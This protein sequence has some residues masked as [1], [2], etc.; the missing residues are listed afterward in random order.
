MLH[1]RA[2][3]GSSRG[4]REAAKVCMV[5]KPLLMLPP[6]QLGK[7]LHYLLYNLPQKYPITKLC[8]SSKQVN[9]FVRTILWRRVAERA[10]RG[11]YFGDIPAEVYPAYTTDPLHI[12]HAFAA[13]LAKLSAFVKQ[14]HQPCS[15]IPLSRPL[16]NKVTRRQK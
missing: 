1:E 14:G 11:T 2:Q 6:P 4:L 7:A 15:F 13:P 8:I 16:G 10:L 12:S 5:T 3:G 9:R